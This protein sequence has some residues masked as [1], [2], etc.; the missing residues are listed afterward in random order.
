MI[1]AA[2][3]PTMTPTSQPSRPD[4]PVLEDVEL[5]ATLV[6]DDAFVAPDVEKIS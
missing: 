4:D 1:I 6:A 5:V 3:G 2:M